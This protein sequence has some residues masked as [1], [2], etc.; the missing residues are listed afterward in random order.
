MVE[1]KKTYESNLVS[2]HRT[3]FLPSSTSVQQLQL[4][5]LTE[6]TCSTCTSTVFSQEACL[7]RP[8]PVPSEVLSQIT[9]DED[10]VFTALRSLNPGKSKGIDVIGPG[11]LKHLPCLFFMWSITSSL[12]VYLFAIYLDF[13]KAFDTAPHTE[14]LHKLSAFGID[15]WGSV[16]VVSIIIRSCIQGTL[17][18]C[19]LTLTLSMIHDWST[20]WSLKFQ[21]KKCVHV[22]F[23][24]SS[25]APVSYRLD[26]HVIESRSTHRDLGVTLC[27]DLSWDHHYDE[28]SA[29]AYRCLGLL[30]RTFCSANCISTKKEL[31]LTLVCSKVMYCSQLWHPHKLKDV[32][33]LE[34][35]QRRATKFIL[36]YLAK[37]TNLAW[38]NYTYCH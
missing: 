8:M 30:R 18:F 6:P 24:T 16:V 7:L 34:A 21:G 11:V 2:L 27:H 26:D 10:E 23:S 3:S 17:T 25:H 38:W 22:R 31:Y 36:G 29:K 32:R 15:I 1:A 20:M 14:L 9:I 12:W 33:K 37:A 19:N 28:T 35:I 5:T 13:A 4:V